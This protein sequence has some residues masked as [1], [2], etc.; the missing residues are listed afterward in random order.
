MRGV[1]TEPAHVLKLHGLS[2]MVCVKSNVFFSKED[3]DGGDRRV[4]G[5]IHE[6]V[7]SG[8][9]SQPPG[10]AY[11]PAPR[12]RKRRGNLSGRDTLPVLRPDVVPPV[13][14]RGRAPAIRPLS[15]SGGRGND[16]RRVRRGGPG[17][18]RQSDPAALVRRRRVTG[19]KRPA[20]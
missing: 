3:P 13:P 7:R 15:G 14:R 18:L 2:V 6:R 12:R 8:Q 1:A 19:K 5:G 11:G 17:R 9:G 4:G 16:G 20:L 10:A